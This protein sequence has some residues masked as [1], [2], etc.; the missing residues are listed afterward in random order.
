MKRRNKFIIG[1]SLIV[2][3]YTSQYIENIDKFITYNSQTVS[4]KPKKLDEST[5]LNNTLKA[6][7][8]RIVDGDTIEVLIDSKKYK[9]RLIGID[10]PEYTSKVEF[11]GKESTQY[12]KSIL[13]NKN[14]FLEKDVSKTDT[15][16]RLLCYVWLETPVEISK[17]EIESKMFNGLLL[18][19]GYANVF[20][21]PPDIKYS[22]IFKELASEAIKNNTGLWKK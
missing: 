11:Y 7:V 15:F 10:C 6:Y 5:I 2:V 1:L 3:I 22:K 9:V 21:Y 14:I 16:G 13:L 20:T 8:S 17:E 18:K 4:N 19:N 12:T